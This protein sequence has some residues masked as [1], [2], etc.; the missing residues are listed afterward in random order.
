MENLKQYEDLIPTIK[1]VIYS[2]LAPLRNEQLNYNEDVA[3][4]EILLFIFK[5]K[6]VIAD[7]DRYEWLAKLQSRASMLAQGWKIN[8]GNQLQ[9]RDDTLDSITNYIQAT[10]GI[11]R[12]RYVA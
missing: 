10:Y 11:N 5:E 9:L 2:C 8:C 6:P 1:Q 7:H 3:C 12:S 4:E